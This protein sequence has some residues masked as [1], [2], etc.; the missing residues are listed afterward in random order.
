MSPTI[1]PP[2]AARPNAA[3]TPPPQRVAAINAAL[4]AS[5]WDAGAGTRALAPHRLAWALSVDL[6]DQIG[7]GRLAQAARLPRGR[8]APRRGARGPALRRGLEAIG[9]VYDYAEPPDAPFTATVT[10]SSNTSA[11]LLGDLAA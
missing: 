7:L 2:S 6:W 5:A 10:A 9:A 4:T 1:A 3:S 8:P 11:L